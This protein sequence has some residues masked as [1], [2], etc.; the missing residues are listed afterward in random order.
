MRSPET[1]AEK[2]EAVRLWLLGGFASSTFEEGLYLAQELNHKVIVQYSLLGLGSVATFRD[3]PARAARLWGAT[4]G[5]YEA[6]SMHLTPLARTNYDGCLSAARSVLGEAEFEE[7][8]MEGKAMT[9]DEAVHYAHFGE[10]TGPAAS[11]AMPKP[12]A[13]EP[14]GNLTRREREVAILVA[15]GLTNRQ[16]STE[17]SISE[18]TAG[19]HV[20]KILRKLGLHSR[21]QIAAHA[22]VIADASERT[23]PGMVAS[24]G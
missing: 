23:A 3:L 11:P 19:N 17:L 4:E 12:A 22:R 10:D 18:R 8:W 24:D 9:V 16:I 7:S 21:A 5:F 15:R 14:M 1:A 6:Y 20:A 2:R 13:G